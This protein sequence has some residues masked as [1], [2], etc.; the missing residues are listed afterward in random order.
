MA[1][2]NDSK[3]KALHRHLDFQIENLERKNYHNRELIT[4]L[5]KQKLKIK[6][7]LYTLSLRE[8]Q[9]NKEQQLDLFSKEGSNVT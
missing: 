8:E 9:R 2:V 3:A 6:D 4:D 7:R 1:T 5:K